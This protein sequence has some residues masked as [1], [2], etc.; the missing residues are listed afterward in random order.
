MWMFGGSTAGS[1]L[2]IPLG[3]PL[4]NIAARPRHSFTG[5]LVFITH[6]CGRRTVEIMWGRVLSGWSHGGNVWVVT[7]H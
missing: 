4:H 3:S 7:P 6:R 2:A 5:L 1:R